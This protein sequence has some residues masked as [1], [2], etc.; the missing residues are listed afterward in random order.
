MEME[1]VDTVAVLGAGSMGHGIA[2]VAALAGY[3]V[4]MRDINEAFVQ[5]GYDRIEWS[6]DKLTEREQI[7]GEEADATLDRI[8]PVVDVADAVGDADVVVEAVPE[9]ME[10]KKDVYADV[11]AHAPDRA[12]FATNTSS[13]SITALSEET[14]RPEQFCGMHF[15]NPP[16]RMQLV[17]V[18]AGAHTEAATLEL[19]EDLAEE[20]GKTPIRV[21]KDSPG[22]V[23][24]RALIPLMNEAC[25]IVEDDIATIA[26]VD[27]TVAHGLGLPMGAFELADQVGNDIVLDVL[28]HMES[29]LGTAYEPS[30]LLERAVEE[31]RLGRKSG[32]G[33]YDYENGEGAEIPSD[34][35]REDV[36]QRLVAVMADEVADLV[37]EDVASV[38]EVDEALQLG[39]GFPEGPAR[40]AD[41]AG[42]DELVETLEALHGETGAGRYA[43]SEH[44]RERAEKG[45]F[46]EGTAPADEEASFEAI[47]VSVTDAGV[48]HVV[49]DRPHR[50]N[51]VTMEMLDEIETALD[52]F[53]D[54]DAV[55]AV[56]IAGAGD[57]AFSAGAD[58]QSWAGKAS[59]LEAVELSRRGQAVF[60][61]FEE[62]PLP[63]VAGID[64]YCLGGGMELATACDL[65]I[66]SERAEFGQP[67]LDLGII[68]GWG[69]TQRLSNIV[70][71]G[72]AREIILVDERFDAGTMADYGFVNRVTGNAEFDEAAMELAE[73]VATGP[74]I[75]MEFAKRAM[76]AG[77]DDTEAGLAVEAQSFG[78]LI[79]T[80]DFMEGVAAFTGDRDPEFEGK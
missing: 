66:A 8:D 79:D 40:M 36:E 62:S 1:D 28:E 39:A 2:E 75:A 80:E 11:E 9:K 69:G 13:L 54:D 49:L 4:R 7:T 21:R 76:L 16:I 32:E 63:I 51:S 29:Q 5:E 6:L 44:L 27:A 17:E 22:F 34:Q 35:R 71:E 18:I 41:E 23:V 60:G 30:P 31:E 19:I 24:N 61:R 70:G 43:V 64:G 72:R 48:G 15:F 59:P 53:E 67:E 12:V 77:R 20:F 52:R 58:V 10:I 57:R 50:L 56:L 3:D 65:R 46:Y 74:P 37:G 33:F 26:E 45:G 78:L 38:R 68:P 55:R 25:W 73:N 14:D 42:L 47:D